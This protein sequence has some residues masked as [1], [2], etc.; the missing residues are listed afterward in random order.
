MLKYTIKQREK[1]CLDQIDYILIV[2]K[3]DEGPRHPFFNIFLLLSSQNVSIEV[4][5]ES[6]ISQINTK[7]L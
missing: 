6:L 3:V 7:L 2:F 5:L 4:L 1:S